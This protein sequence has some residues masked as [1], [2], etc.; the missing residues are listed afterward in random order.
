MD[1]VPSGRRGIVGPLAL[2]IVALGVVWGVNALSSPPGRS[3]DAAASTTDPHPSIAEAPGATTNGP[4][5]QP[6]RP[7]ATRIAAMIKHGVSPF[8]SHGRCCRTSAATFG[9]RSP[10]ARVIAY[11]QGH[12][13]HYA[14]PPLV[15]SG[16]GDPHTSGGYLRWLGERGRSPGT[17]RQANVAR[18]SLVDR[19]RWRT[20]FTVSRAR[21]GR[22][23]APHLPPADLPQH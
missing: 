19:P 7:V 8:C 9:T 16:S 11:F 12:R 2:L 21:C 18:G 10:I 17:W 1:D 22:P 3:P 20:V 13:F 4:R 14:A 5:A 6:L 15:M 23:F